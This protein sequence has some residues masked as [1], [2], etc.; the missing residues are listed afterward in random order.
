MPLTVNLEALYFWIRQHEVYLYILTKNNHPPGLQQIYVAK[1]V[2]QDKEKA[3]CTSFCKDRKISIQITELEDTYRM[4]FSC[5]LQVRPNKRN[6][7]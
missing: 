4:M 3:K 1:V 6:I 7:K 2:Q 5:D